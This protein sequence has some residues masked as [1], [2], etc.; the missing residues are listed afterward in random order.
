MRRAVYVHRA[1]VVTGEFTVRSQRSGTTSPE[2]AM[3]R[4]ILGSPR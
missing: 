4:V 2:P 1:R 3:S